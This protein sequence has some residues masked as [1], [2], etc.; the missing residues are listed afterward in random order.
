MLGRFKRQLSSQPPAGTVSGLEVLN[1]DR[2][3]TYYRG[4][5][6]NHAGMTGMF[7]GRRP[8]EYGSPIW[9]CVEVEAGRVARFV[10]LPA[11]KSRWRGCDEAWHLQ[12]AVD[13]FNNQPQLYRVRR[14]G[15]ECRFDFFSPLPQW[16]ERR[17]IMFGHPVPRENCLMSYV[18]PDSAATI[19][20]RF[21]QERL[22][23]S[24]VEEAG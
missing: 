10:D 8:Q 4:R 3:V 9:C 21:L 23:L 12:M 6:T 2:P 20:G 17:L 7:V 14:E 15:D 24:R 11:K 16:S 19:E 18:L 1:V 13:H 5:W 22:W